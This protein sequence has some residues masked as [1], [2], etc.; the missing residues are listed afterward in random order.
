MRRIKGAYKSSG[1]QKEFNVR[2]VM[3]LACEGRTEAQY[4]SYIGRTSPVRIKPIV[5]P[6]V[7]GEHLVDMALEY[8]ARLRRTYSDAQITPA[9]MYDLESYSTRNLEF[10]RIV[11]KYAQRKKV[12]IWVNIPS[13]E[14]WFVLHYGH[15][16]IHRSKKSATAELV[17]R[18]SVARSPQYKKPGNSGFY[19]RLIPLTR[20][21]I[22][23]C[24]RSHELDIG[25][26]ALPCLCSF[27]IFIESDIG[28]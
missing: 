18:L 23:N 12:K 19:T 7:Q 25:S 14:R 28:G 3:A 8:A 9:V 17:K 20:T 27:I 24:T 10:A 6:G 4:A 13:I 5:N 22:D 16:S 26:K 1:A 15:F 2:P 11:V 21:A